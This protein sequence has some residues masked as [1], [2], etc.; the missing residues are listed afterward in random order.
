METQT[1][2]QVSRG[3]VTQAERIVSI[4]V[5]RGFAVLGILVMNIQSFSMIGAAYLNPTAYGDLTGANHAAWLLSH[6]LADRKFITIFSMLF[7]AGIV[8]MSSRREALGAG[9]AGVH[10]RRMGLLLLVGLL[11]G[12]LLWYGDILHAYALCGL[13]VFLFRRKRPV[14]LLVVGLAS[15][16]VASA[17][18]FFFHW[19]LNHWPAEAVEQSLAWWNP[20]EADVASEV[21]ALRGGWVEQ[22]PQRTTT[23]IFFQ[24]FLFAIEVAWRSG[25]LMLVGMALFKL[26]VFSA[27]RSLGFSSCTA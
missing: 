18:S 9:G 23:A 2:S 27:K 6:V 25:G 7:G 4:D 22:L 24:T 17:L 13:A 5:L 12:H 3:P 8:L 11:H 21:A 15:V 20:R 19:S 1:A 14:T 10:Y 16:S 26:G